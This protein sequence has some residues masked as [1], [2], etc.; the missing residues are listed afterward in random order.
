MPA[1]PIAIRWLPQPGSRHRTS[2]Q[3]LPQISKEGRRMGH[4][5]PDGGSRRHLLYVHERQVITSA[6]AGRIT[7]QQRDEAKRRC[8]AGRPAGIPQES[9][10]VSA[11]AI[12]NRRPGKLVCMSFSHSLP[13]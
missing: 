3:D 11:S 12:S 10:T 1:V 13:R 8:P 2:G 4:P 5:Q 9:W 6:Q 7:F